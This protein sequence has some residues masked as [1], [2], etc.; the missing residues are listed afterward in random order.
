MHRFGDD[1]EDDFEDEDEFDS[2]EDDESGFVEEDED[3]LLADGGQRCPL[4]GKR[5]APD[6]LE[7]CEH[8]H[9]VVWDDELILGGDELAP[10]WEELE[11]LWNEQ[12]EIFQD[13]YADELDEKL[14]RAPVGVQ[15]VVRDGLMDENPLFWTEDAETVD[16]ER[17]GGGDPTGS[18]FA[19]YHRNPDFME[20]L[21]ND[22]QRA[23]RF[24]QKFADARLED[25]DDS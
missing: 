15:R 7:S 12:D 8:Y 18:G 14:A 16:R 21:V 10:A 3:D 1:D 25:D 2:M 5:G 17:A 24:L 19:V 9:A 20:R 23:R 11:E 6:D 4:C 13:T 22:V